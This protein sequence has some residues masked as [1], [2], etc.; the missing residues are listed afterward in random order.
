MKSEKFKII[1]FIR[2]FIKTLSS[3]LDSFPKK[4]YELKERIKKNSYDI[5]EIA[6]E[7]NSTEF[8]ELKINLI[9][10][11]LA[12]LKLIDYLL[13][14]AVEMELLSNKKYLKMANRL[15]DIEKY[16]RGWLE[17]TKKGLTIYKKDKENYLQNKDDTLV[18]KENKLLNNTKG[19]SKKPRSY[20]P[21]D[22]I[23]LS[24]EASKNLEQ[25]S[26]FVN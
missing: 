3:N 16:S 2:I 23:L 17:Q 8:V 22:K 25:V 19:K 21:P 15:A 1:D 6:Y 24:N 13:D 18:I 14:L 4:E 9:N 5:L 20:Q 12:K 11:M 10:K 26:L 7:A